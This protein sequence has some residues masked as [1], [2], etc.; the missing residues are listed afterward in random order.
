MVNLNSVVLEEFAKH[1]LIIHEGIAVD[2]RLVKSASRP[3][4]RDGLRELQEQR[5]QGEGETDKNRNPVK[6][7]RDVESDWTVK[8]AVPHYGL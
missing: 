8:N 2:A 4:S 1:G 7:R 3:V 6:F 5:D